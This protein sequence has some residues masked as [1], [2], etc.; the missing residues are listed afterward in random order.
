VGR[1]RSRGVELEADFRP[2]SVLHFSG[3]YT[4]D[5]A[6]LSESG[7]PAL[8][9]KQVRNVARHQFVLRASADEPSVLSASV[10]A[11]FVGDRFEDDRNTLPLDALFVVDVL[12]SRRATR[13]SEVFV[14]VEN[15]FD[16][17]FE[18]RTTTTGLVEVGAP[19]SVQGGVRL[20]L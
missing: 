10:Q 17:E 6:V 19:R 5:D 11:R 2:H 15:V 13:W 18:V 8:V 1:L 3:S 14:S 16:T 4:F 20:N 12:V 9:G 7:D